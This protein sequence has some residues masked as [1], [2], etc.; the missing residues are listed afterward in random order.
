MNST[1]ELT[2]DWND[3]SL[4]IS[5]FRKIIRFISEGNECQPLISQGTVALTERFNKLADIRWK[6]VRSNERIE[7]YLKLDEFLI[8]LKN[9]P[10]NIDP[11]VIKH[12]YLV[13]NTLEKHL[14]DADKQI[15]SEAISL[16]KI[17]YIRSKLRDTYAYVSN[18]ILNK[19]ILSTPDK[20]NLI[21][22]LT[23]A[24][25]QSKAYE[26]QLSDLY[27]DLISLMKDLEQF[28]VSTTN[29]SNQVLDVK[30]FSNGLYSS[31]K[32][33]APKE[34]FAFDSSNGISPT[35]FDLKISYN[36]NGKIDVTDSLIKKVLPLFKKRFKR[37]H[38]DGN[39]IIFSTKLGLIRYYKSQVNF[40]MNDIHSMSKVALKIAKANG[41]QQICVWG[42][43]EFKSS[44]KQ[45]AKSYGITVNVITDHLLNVTKAKIETEDEPILSQSNN[46]VQIAP[47]RILPSL[48]QLRFG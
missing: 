30:P 27:N 45:M 26:N 11:N 33:I 18:E 47:Q 12:G 39:S 32:K 44:I 22:I 43:P 5:N 42:T 34:R 24:V 7:N 41:W 15:V 17:E 21:H 8:S 23:K 19:N 4:Y 37:E 28:P 1:S 13:L 48:K 40:D 31:L 6:L 29:K 20:A 3:H 2:L 25:K 10:L 16:R 9:L 38:S 36:H 14:N 35:L 46:Q